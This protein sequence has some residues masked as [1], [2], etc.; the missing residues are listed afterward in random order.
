M[1]SILANLSPIWGYLE[2]IGQCGVISWYFVLVRLILVLSVV[3]S[4]FCMG[5][6]DQFP[7]CIY[8]FNVLT[9]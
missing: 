3:L 1:C 9:N 8:Y 4:L 7:H 6:M 5:Q 2:Y